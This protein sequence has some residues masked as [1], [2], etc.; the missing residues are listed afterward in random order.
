MYKHI[1]LA[2]DGSITG[3]KALLELEELANVVREREEWS[4]HD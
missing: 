3:Q 4:T 2:Y 1:I